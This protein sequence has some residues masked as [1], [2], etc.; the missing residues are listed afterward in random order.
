M[1]GSFTP[2][3]FLQVAA[4]IPF[5]NELKV[6]IETGTH[7]GDT[8]R[9]A[10]VIFNEVYTFEI[11]KI[12]YEFAKRKLATLDCTNVNHQ[13]GDSVELLDNLLDTEYRPAFFFLDAHHHAMRTTENVKMDNGSGKTPLMD[14]L[15]IINT[16]YPNKSKAVIC[17]DDVRL[18]RSGNS[19]WSNVNDEKII[20]ALNNHTIVNS[21]EH[22]DRLYFLINS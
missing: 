22:G 10:S 6:F 9:I 20:E 7:Q 3:E 12:F 1:G 13:L 5:F 2:E 19:D 18:W 15:E 8:T 21:F 16:K 11:N 17:I 14:E 4:K